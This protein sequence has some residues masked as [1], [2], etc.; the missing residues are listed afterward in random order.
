LAGDLAIAGALKDALSPL[1]SIVTVKSDSE[2]TLPDGSKAIVQDR[3]RNPLAIKTLMN[4]LGMPSGPARQPLGRM[5]LEG[6]EQVRKAAKTVWDR[7]PEILAPI[8]EFYGVDVEARI[9]SAAIWNELS[10]P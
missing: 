9:N 3:F 5:T 4:G 1:F 8:K 2:R 10:Y 7:N 6:V